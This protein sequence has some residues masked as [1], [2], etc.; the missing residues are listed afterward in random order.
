MSYRVV[1]YAKIPEFPAS[2]TSSL[3][4]HTAY[5]TSTS[6]VYYPVATVFQDFGE[7]FLGAQK[8]ADILNLDGKYP[9]IPEPFSA[10]PTAS[11]IPASYIFKYLVVSTDEERVTI[12]GIAARS[13]IGDYPQSIYLGW[14]WENVPI[15]AAIQIV[16]YYNSEHAP[17]NDSLANYPQFYTLV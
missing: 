6:G 14:Y 15:S 16:N 17:L 13:N 11:E 2:Q 10:P 1:C 9:H 12:K 5:P 4:I 3:D 8:M 7:D